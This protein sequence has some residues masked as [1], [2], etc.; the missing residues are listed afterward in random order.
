MPCITPRAPSPARIISCAISSYPPTAW[1]RLP[2]PTLRSTLLG[3]AKRESGRKA[4]RPSFGRRGTADDAAPSSDLS[5]A[6]TQLWQF[7]VYS[8]RPDA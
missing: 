8:G 1:T 5:T 2:P 3:H 4:V 7:W 6:I